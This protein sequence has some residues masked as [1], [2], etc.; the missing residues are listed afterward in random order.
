MSYKPVTLG[1]DEEGP[2][3]TELMVAGLAACAAEEAAIRLESS[4]EDSG[5]MEV[6]ADFEWD[7]DTGRVASIRLSVALPEQT[8]ERTRLRVL[9]AMY[10]CPALK[11]LTEPPSVDY[12]L[13][14]GAVQLGIG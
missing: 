2:T 8:S 14:T 3:P 9:R 7:L 4:G 13:T 12:K 5:P 1:A 10:R 6:G 11:L